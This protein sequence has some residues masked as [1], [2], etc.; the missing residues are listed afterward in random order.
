MKFSNFTPKYSQL[1][2]LALSFVAGSLLFFRLLASESV[3]N[4]GT[5]PRLFDSP[6]AAVTALQAA[7]S[8]NDQAAMAD[9]FGPEFREMLTGDG[10]W[11]QT[12]S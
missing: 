5:A 3:A 6:E 12:I 10:C 11:L 7:T 9:L 8:A 1:F 2:T 4:P